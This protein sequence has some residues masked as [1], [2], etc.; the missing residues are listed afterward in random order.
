MGESRS[1]RMP[2]GWIM[3]R[4]LDD[5]KYSDSRHGD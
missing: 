2:G 3:V 4:V 1:W 5:G